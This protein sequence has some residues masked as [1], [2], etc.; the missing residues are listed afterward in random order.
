LAE[1]RLSWFGTEGKAHDAIM[2]LLADVDALTQERDALAAELA[3]YK[4]QAA[5][6]SSVIE[7]EGKYVP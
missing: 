2:A 4:R 7:S 3:S 5:Y 6:I 1:Q